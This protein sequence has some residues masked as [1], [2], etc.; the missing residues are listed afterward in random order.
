MVFARLE[1]ARALAAARLAVERE[2]QSKRQ[3]DDLAKIALRKAEE[4]ALEESWSAWATARGGLLAEGVEAGYAMHNAILDCAIGQIA[5]GYEAKMLCHGSGEYRAHNWELR[6]SPTADALRLEKS[7]AALI[8]KASLPPSLTI[9]DP[10]VCRVTVTE[11]EYGEDT[12]YTAV[13]ITLESPLTKTRTLI[14]R[15]E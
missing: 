11:E 2:E 8:K 3:K 12:K 1:E 4:K 10:E 7:L 14:F 15:C 6:D 5:A 13:V 9:Y